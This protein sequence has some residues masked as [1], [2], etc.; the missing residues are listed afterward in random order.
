MVIWEYSTIRFIDI[1]VDRTIDKIN[2]S[3]YFV[4]S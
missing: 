3:I 2:V 4:D 1:T